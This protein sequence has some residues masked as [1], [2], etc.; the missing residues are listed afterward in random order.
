[1]QT[2]TAIIVIGAAVMALI[3]PKNTAFA[4]NC[5]P[6]EATAQT[7]KSS[8][9]APAAVAKDGAG[10]TGW[11]GGMGGA[12]AGTENQKQQAAPESQPE[13]ARGLDLKGVPA[14]R[15]CEQR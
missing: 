14:D 1:M 6:K 10:T 4:G 13:E 2:R 11:T 7:Q 12:S 15:K 8:P 3:A 9:P 5:P